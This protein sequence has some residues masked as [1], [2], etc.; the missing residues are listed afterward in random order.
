[1]SD[2]RATVTAMNPP[3]ILAL[4]RRDRG[5]TLQEL[6][7]ASGIHRVTIVR[8]EQR[9]HEPKYDTLRRLADALDCDW[10]DLIEEGA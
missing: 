3:T 5:M 1:M 6:A 10:R 4:T 8:L 7:D 9:R 2:T